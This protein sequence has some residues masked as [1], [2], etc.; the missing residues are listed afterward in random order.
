MRGIKSA[1]LLAGQ[2]LPPA[3]L[4]S[5]Y[6]IHE[7]LLRAWLAYPRDRPPIPG[8]LTHLAVT[9]VKMRTNLPYRCLEHLTGIARATL[10]RMVARTSLLLATLPLP[11]LCSSALVDTTTI[12]L[13]RGACIGD[14][15]GYK[16]LQGIKIQIRW[17]SKAASVVCAA[18]TR[19]AGMTSGSLKQRLKTPETYQQ[20]SL[21]IKRISAWRTSASK[22]RK[23][24]T[25]S[26]IKRTRQPRNARIVRPTAN[27]SWLNIPLLRSSAARSFTRD[28]TSP[29]KRYSN[30]STALA[31]STMLKLK[32]GNF[33]VPSYL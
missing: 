29:G 13:G 9:L 28:S 8:L 20:R 31:S 21:A 3:A 16:H 7:S 4:R 30:C 27:V 15:T 22:Y 2:M 24:G 6:F 17:I 26:A 33:N 23:S 10:A 11:P 1:F 32:Q 5:L 19:R 14:Y 25:T 12:R 18:R